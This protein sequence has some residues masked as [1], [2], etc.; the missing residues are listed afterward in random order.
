MRTKQLSPPVPITRTLQLAHTRLSKNLLCRLIG[1]AT[2]VC[3]LIGMYKLGIV[4]WPTME[5]LV[6]DLRTRNFFIPIIG[7]TL[8]FV[9]INAVY[10]VLY[11][12]EHP[13]F[14][15]YKTNDSE[16]PWKTD[17]EFK[18]KLKK[19]AIVI[20]MNLIV[21]KPIF[22]GALNFGGA[23]NIRGKSDDIPPFHVYL[24]HIVFMFLSD[25]LFSYI[26]HWLLHI[27]AVYPYFH[28]I[29][30][31]YFESLSFVAEYSHPVEFIFGNL[32]PIGTGPLFLFG[33]CHMLSLM[34][35]LLIRIL[36]TVE[37]HSGYDFPWA[38]T[39]LLPF[40]SDSD[41]HDYHHLKNL[42]NFGST[43]VIWDSI[44]G[45]NTHYFEEVMKKE[46]ELKLKTK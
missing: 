31:E 4:L 35:F 20:F 6:P 25:D 12:L 41:Y 38:M 21:W 30:H 34:G 44:F 24:L 33:R 14:E 11:V 7:S 2:L 46:K 40:Q 29:H 15:Q 43:T 23:A 28:K 36:A 3:S 37:N 26:T 32:V 19:A 45:T 10:L 16:W 9:A 13:F 42:G 1:L 18:P 27:P 5:R 8:I 22:S 39:R 17:P